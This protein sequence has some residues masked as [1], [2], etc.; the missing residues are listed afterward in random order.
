MNELLP[1][2]WGPIPASLQASLWWML[3]SGNQWD[4]NSI[5]ETNNFIRKK[6]LYPWNYYMKRFASS[7]DLPYITLHLQTTGIWESKKRLSSTSLSMT[8]CFNFSN[9][10]LNYLECIPLLSW[11]FIVLKGKD[12]SFE[13][14]SDNLQN[15]GKNNLSKMPYFECQI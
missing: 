12:Y 13:L 11:K 8:S 2:R 14:T 4:E 9:T 5:R 15:Y 6:C 3:P 7:K 1:L 10:I